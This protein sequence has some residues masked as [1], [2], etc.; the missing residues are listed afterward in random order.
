KMNGESSV[1]HEDKEEEEEDFLDPNSAFVSVAVNKNK[2]ST[3]ANTAIIHMDRSQ[4]TTS[5]KKT[6]DPE[7][8]VVIESE[9]L[10]VEGYKAASREEYAK[11]VEYFTKAIH[12]VHNDHR[13]FGNRSFCYCQLGQYGKALK[14]AEKSIKFAPLSAKG[15]YRRGEALRGLKQYKQAE[16][17]FERVVQLDED[18]ED[19][20][21]ELENVR[22][23]QVMEMGFSEDQAYTAVQQYHTVQMAVEM[24]TAENSA[25]SH[26]SSAGDIFYSDDEDGFLST[27]SGVS[28]SQQQQQQAAAAVKQQAN[29]MD[30]S[31]P[32]G[33]SSLW[34]GN[35]T[36]SVTEKQLIELFSRFGVV[37][38]VR[39]LPEKFCA[40]I[41]FR[42]K[43]A[44]GP[45]MKYL[46]GKEIGGEKLLIRYPNN[47]VPEQ[48]VLKKP[49]PITSGTNQT[50]LTGPVNGDECHFWRTTGCAFGDKCR[51]KHRK[52]NKGID[53]KPW[54]ETNL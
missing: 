37:L 47:P 2:R 32:E 18:C 34:V 52:E 4:R 33:Q 44:P 10:A 46:Q 38:S 6:G 29:K 11:A 9:S 48:I 22:I 15:Y 25:L 1:T 51:Y 30:P 19:A 41:N 12:L 23:Q 36:Q 54:A 8:A 40:F 7:D 49:A 27:A 21:Q 39:L 42:D 24:L 17:A 13:F 20:K 53:K 16:E 35:I 43:S 31:N 45:A 28:R 26:N 3:G 5:S 14:D 50:K